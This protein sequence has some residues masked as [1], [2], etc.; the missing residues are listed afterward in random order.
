MKLIRYSI[1]YMVNML[2]ITEKLKT[3]NEQSEEILQLQQ[4]V[5]CVINNLSEVTQLK[6]AEELNK[7]ELAE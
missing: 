4:K 2:Q 3:I 1:L 5:E 6:D 7:T